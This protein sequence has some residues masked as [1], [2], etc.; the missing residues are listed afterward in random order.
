MNLLD[1]LKQAEAQ[2]TTEHDSDIHRMATCPA[3][4]AER[5]IRELLRNHAA[6]L[7]RLVEAAKGLKKS[8][9]DWTTD[10]P[11]NLPPSLSSAEELDTA[12]APFL[13][14]EDAR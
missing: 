8:T 14:E 11:W 12:L 5:N 7:I 4:N 9:T 2:L 13:A 10:K 6:D 1:R 3:C